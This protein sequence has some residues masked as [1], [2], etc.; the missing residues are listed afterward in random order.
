MRTML[1]FETCS[2]LENAIYAH[3]RYTKANQIHFSISKRVT[4]KLAIIIFRDLQ[5]LAGCTGSSSDFKL[6]SCISIKQNT[7]RLCLQLSGFHAERIPL[8]VL[9]KLNSHYESLTFRYNLYKK[10][11]FY[12]F[13][14]VI[15]CYNLLIRSQ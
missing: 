14:S 10:L 5:L 6:A 15:I 3:C 7:T 1:N 9:F 12:I 8:S 11:V 4:I 13:W 2:I